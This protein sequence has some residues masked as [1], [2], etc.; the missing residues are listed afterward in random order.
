MLRAT[1]LVRG[2]ANIKTRDLDW[3][4]Y[5]D[6]PMP[7]PL[8]KELRFLSTVNLLNIKCHNLFVEVGGYY[9]ILKNMLNNH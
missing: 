7:A 5:P 6:S 3:E 2:R 8:E 1:Q 4:V 9:G